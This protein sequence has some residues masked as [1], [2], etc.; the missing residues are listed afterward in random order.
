MAIKKNSPYDNYIELSHWFFISHMASFIYY[1]LSY[2]RL[3]DIKWNGDRL[4]RLIYMP[5]TQREVF[6]WRIINKVKLRVLY[7][8]LIQRLISTLFLT[9]I[10]SSWHPS[11]EPGT[12]AEESEARRPRASNLSCERLDYD[13]CL[14]RLR[15]CIVAQ[16]DPFME[17][18][19]FCNFTWINRE[20]LHKPIQDFESCEFLKRTTN[21]L[22]T[23]TCK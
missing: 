9:E 7:L 23:G 12:E 10:R 3:G 16:N 17:K 8:N 18:L 14:S 5:S 1:G 19:P 4:W 11:A 2:W 21:I 6:G 13:A 15:G 20:Y 22:D